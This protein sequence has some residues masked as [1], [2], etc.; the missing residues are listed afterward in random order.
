MEYLIS[1]IK[2]FIFVSI[3]NVWFIR[4]NKS[5]SWRGGEASS[6]REEFKN[7]GLSETVMYVVGG[8]KVLSALALLLS[9]WMPVLTSPAAALMAVLMAGA[10]AMHI[11]INDPL[12]S[13]FPAFSFLV[14]SFILI[15]F[16]QGWF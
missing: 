9:I 3:F 10:I 5:T 6:M 7:Y 4:F 12:R 2:L 8:L 13:S 14:L 1:A 16:N 11:K 15:A